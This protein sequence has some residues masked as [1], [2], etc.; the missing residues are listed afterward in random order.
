M[1]LWCSVPVRGRAYGAE[2]VGSVVGEEP[3][4]EAETPRPRAPAYAAAGFGAALA[5]TVLPWTTFGEGSTA[6]GAW[7]LS[8][9]WALLA[10]LAAA[11]G[12]GVAVLRLRRQGVDP[13]WDALAIALGA[14]VVL[15]ALLEWFRPPFP[16][17][18][19]LV[20]WIAVGGGLLAAASAL[21]CL[22]EDSRA[23]R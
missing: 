22:L 12:L 8:P 19:S 10:A 5:A 13:R 17:R 15:G 21:R 20:P 1:C 14:A 9:R 7:T 4:R 23:A 3:P 11:V 18:P 6:F 2:C 16:S